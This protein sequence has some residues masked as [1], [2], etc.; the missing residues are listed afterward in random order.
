MERITKN[1]LYERVQKLQAEG[2]NIAVK[3]AYDRPRLETVDGSK[4]LS[5]RDTP[6]MLWKWLDGYVAGYY[7]AKGE[8]NNVPSK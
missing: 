1:R 4:Y 8:K 3:S 7:T 6:Y 5:D 2:M